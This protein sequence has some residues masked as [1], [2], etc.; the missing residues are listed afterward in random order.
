MLLICK[1]WVTVFFLPLLFICSKKRQGQYLLKTPQAR[2]APSLPYPSQ[3]LSL[4][5][6]GP[7]VPPD[8]SPSIQPAPRRNKTQRKQQP[9]DIPVQ[10]F[11][12]PPPSPATATCPPAP[13]PPPP[14]PPPPPPPPLPPT[15]PPPPNSSED[16]PM[17]LSEE[18]A[19]PFP[20]RNMLKQN[21]GE[22]LSN[23]SFWCDLVCLFQINVRKGV[24]VF[25]CPYT[26]F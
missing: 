8:G 14:L 20:A 26:V 12:A 10:I 21:I 13:P 4:I 24:F 3:P 2:V 25:V 11:S 22:I 19:P 7:S 16:A 18:K 17:P 6:L 23:A 9:K 5:S 1:F 15:L